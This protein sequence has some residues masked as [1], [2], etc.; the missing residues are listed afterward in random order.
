MQ[1]TGRAAVINIMGKTKRVISEEQEEL[2]ETA[3]EVGLNISIK[4]Q[5]GGT[6]RKRRSEILTINDHDI[7]FVRSFKYLA[8]A[9]KILLMKLKK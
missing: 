1:L 8:N 5:I 2:E 6:I 9:I 3:K 4:I 7:E